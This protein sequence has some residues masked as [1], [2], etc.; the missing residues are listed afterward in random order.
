MRLL[1]EEAARQRSRAIHRSI[2]MHPVRAARDSVST[3][4]APDATA[5]GPRKSLRT[6][7]ATAKE[8]HSLGEV[9]AAHRKLAAE[10]GHQAEAVVCAARE[11]SQHR[12]QDVNPQQ[13]VRESITFSRDKN[14]EREAV[15]D[16]R[17]L[18]RDALR[19][20]I[21]EITYP[22]MRANLEF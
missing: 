20:G 14:F 5:K 21:G 8:I 17:S 15:V 22:Q 9:M 1:L 6:R 2:L 12:T 4:K 10:Y 16:E 7:P 19:R 3:W 18:V 11:R 13:R